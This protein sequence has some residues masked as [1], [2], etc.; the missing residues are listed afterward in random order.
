MV[1]GG[2]FGVLILLLLVVP[3]A[4]ATLTMNCPASAQATHPFTISASDSSASTIKI[5]TH[6]WH[7]FPDST[8][9]QVSV[10]EDTGMEGR[11][12]HYYAQSYDSGDN[13]IG[14]TDCYVNILSANFPCSA[15]VSP[16]S[17]T[18]AMH[19]W[20][21]ASVSASDD[22]GVNH[23]FLG[24][25]GVSCSGYPSTCSHPFSL[26]FSRAGTYTLTA[27]ANDKWN[28]PC[29]T[30]SLLTVH[31]TDPCANTDCNDSNPCTD[32]TCTVD[33][34]GQAQCEHTNSPAD[35]YCGSNPSRHCDG[36]GSCL[37]DCSNMADTLCLSSNPGHTVTHTDHYCSN[38]RI[39][40]SCSPGFH[41]SGDSCVQDV[42]CTRVQRERDAL[43]PGRGARG[44]VRPER[45]ER[46]LGMEHTTILPER[47][48][49]H[50]R[51]VP[52]PLPRRAQPVRAATRSSRRCRGRCRR[53]T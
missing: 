4:S 7:E 5:F 15:S 36:Y 3:L 12:A 43:L 32:D 26:S 6:E 33:E 10:T 37:V 34:Q 35:T 38:S 21:H 29:E 16:S 19:Q 28:N 52:R 25:N 11:K 39:C 14:S 24:G 49:V 31:V 2:W 22:D 18:V 40:Y 30:T 9:G 46:V 17:V 48:N 53:P 42:T 45:H 50:G 41:W 47:R 27:S 20:V 13:Q 8:Y 1:R 23:L 44:A 51:L